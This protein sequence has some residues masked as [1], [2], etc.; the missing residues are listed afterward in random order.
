MLAVL[1]PFFALRFWRVRHL[2]KPLIGCILGAATAFVL[3]YLS[4]LPSILEFYAKYAPHYDQGLYV[5]PYL[6][7]QVGLLLIAAAGVGLCLACL[8]PRASVSKDVDLILIWTAVTILLSYA[9]LFGVQWHGVRWIHFI[10]Q[11]LT[12]LAGFGFGVLRKRRPVA[13]A[14]ILVFMIQLAFSVQGYYSDIL[15]YLVP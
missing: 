5:T 12:I 13:V 11:P 10:P 15:R 4:A 2:E 7:E 9:Y 1:V 8:R 6:L 3:F 14:L